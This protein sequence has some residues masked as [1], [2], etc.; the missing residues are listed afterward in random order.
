MNKSI[1]FRMKP[2]KVFLLV[3]GFCLASGMVKVFGQE[4]MSLKQV[5][6]EQ[7]KTTH[8]DKDWFVPANL[9][10]AGL[11]AEQ[12]NWDDGHGNHSIG[13]LATHLIFWN[14]RMLQQFQGKKLPA[15]EGDNQET[16][17]RFNQAEWE[18][19]IQKLDEVLT[20]WENAVQNA[21]DSQVNQWASTIAH[22]GT[23]NAYHVGQ[24]IYIRKDRGWWDAENGVK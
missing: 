10:V 1:V 23:H 14:E 2:K 24:I 5:L 13:Q 15:F 3:I 21:D 16:F 9:A 8:G 7:L 4:T 19:T 18:A 22:I 17:T 12:A 20:A 6:I 11:T